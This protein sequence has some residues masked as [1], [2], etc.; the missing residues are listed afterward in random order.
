VIIAPTRRRLAMAVLVI[1][2]GAGLRGG[3]SNVAST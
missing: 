3:V 1:G 2:I